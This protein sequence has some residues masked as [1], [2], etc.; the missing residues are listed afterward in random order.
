V[1]SSPGSWERLLLV[2]SRIYRANRVWSFPV[3]W[4]S[5][6]RTFLQNS[7]WSAPI[8]ALA[9]LLQIRSASKY[10]SSVRR[11]GCFL[12]AGICGGFRG[13]PPRFRTGFDIVSASG[14]KEREA[15]EAWEVW[16]AW[17]SSASW[18]ILGK[19]VGEVGNDVC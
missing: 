16:E 18:A 1:A 15:W 14:G 2:R 13:R 19:S 3:F 5:S 4:R 9:S 8:Y 12:G 7:V 11:I 17:E 10:S 6:S